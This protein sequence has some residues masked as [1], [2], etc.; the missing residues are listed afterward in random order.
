MTSRSIELRLIDEKPVKSLLNALA[1][2]ASCATQC[3][4]CRMHERI[5][6]EALEE[7]KRHYPQIGNSSA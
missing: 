5:A 7:F 3:E 2:I 4:C 1:G 6:R